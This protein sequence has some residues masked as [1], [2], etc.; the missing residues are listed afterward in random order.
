M[1]KNRNEITGDKLITKKK[2]KAFDDNFDLIFRKKERFEGYT[3]IETGHIKKEPTER[4]PDPDW[5][6]GRI[7]VIGQ[8]GNDG[9]HYAWTKHDESS[10]CPT[11]PNAWIAVETYTSNSFVELAR[12]LEWKYVKFY[13]VVSK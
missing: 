5:D 8:N 11:E 4:D 3:T 2:T 9:Q 1:I 7:D 6:E 12:N 13:R 10:T